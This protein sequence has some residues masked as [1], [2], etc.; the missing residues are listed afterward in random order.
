MAY[1][2]SMTIRETRDYLPKQSNRFF[3]GERAVS[4]YIVE[5]LATF[6]VFKNKIAIA[7]SSQVRKVMYCLQLTVRL[8]SPRCRIG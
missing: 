2:E 7:V 8:G 6:D 1:I 5:K 4:R 3:F